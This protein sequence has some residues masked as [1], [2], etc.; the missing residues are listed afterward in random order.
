MSI[1]GV[2][3]D[4]VNQVGK[5]ETVRDSHEHGLNNFHAVWENTSDL[6]H[7]CGAWLYGP[8][9]RCWPRES[10][11]PRAKQWLRS[12]KRTTWSG[13]TSPRR[14]SQD[15]NFHKGKMATGQPGEMI[16]ARLL[17]LA[18]ENQR[19]RMRL[20]CTPGQGTVPGQE[21][22]RWSLLPTSNTGLLT[23]PH[24]T[25]LTVNGLGHL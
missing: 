25:K 19:M 16:A 5:G 11:R 12:G 1:P 3:N 6:R 23:L 2:Y 7:T 8:S 4:T 24:I 21:D 18:E 9:W 14:S 13:L 10:W 20:H 22:G 15:T 17:N